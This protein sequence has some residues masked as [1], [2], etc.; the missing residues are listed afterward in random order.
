MQVNVWTVNEAD[1]L[2]RLRDAGVDGVVTDVPDL[3]R[4]VLRA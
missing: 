3:A 2:L 1:Q 4:T